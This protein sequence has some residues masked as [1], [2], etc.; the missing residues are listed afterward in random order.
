MTRL[1]SRFA[2]VR[3]LG[4]ISEANPFRHSNYQGESLGA[5]SKREILILDSR[6]SRFEKREETWGTTQIFVPGSANIQS[7]YEQAYVTEGRFFLACHDAKACLVLFNE[8]K[9]QETKNI[10][11]DVRAEES[12]QRL[13]SYSSLDV[14]RCTTTEEQRENIAKFPLQDHVL[15][16]RLGRSEPLDQTARNMDSIRSELADT[17]DTEDTRSLDREVT[18]IRLNNETL[19]TYAVSHAM[20]TKRVDAALARYKELWAQLSLLNSVS[21]SYPDIFAECQQTYHAVKASLEANQSELRNA[22]QCVTAQEEKM[23]IRA[24]RR[25]EAA[26]LRHI[27]AISRA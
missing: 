21:S 5:G 22:L 6:T 10:R 14:E 11:R 27:R 15:L 1:F 20:A 9:Y 18:K 24:K 12:V 4:E 13:R 3:F 7:K 17:E 26:Y 23:R 2:A 25:A 19:N 16:D 8:S